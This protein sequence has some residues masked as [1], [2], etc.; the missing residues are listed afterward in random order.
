MSLFSF[1]PPDYQSIISLRP[2]LQI[3]T[4]VI[5]LINDQDQGPVLLRDSHVIT[6]R[7]RF[8]T[9]QTKLFA[10]CH[11]FDK[12]LKRAD[13]LNVTQVQRQSWRIFQVSFQSVSTVTLGLTFAVF[14][15]QT[16]G[17]AGKA[18]QNW[19]LNGSL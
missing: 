1:P 5:T 12:L 14:T 7:I 13:P 9:F 11:Q 10:Q 15:L 16:T 17:K 4:P 3:S 18:V 2:R 19:Q 6:T 8:N